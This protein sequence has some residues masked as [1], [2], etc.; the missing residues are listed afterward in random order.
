MF[1]IY[2]KQIFEIEASKAKFIN[3][4]QFCSNMAIVG[5]SFT[6]I[7]VERKDGP[8]GKMKV[9]NN[10][11]LKKLEKVPLALAGTENCL[12]LSFSFEALYEPK[13]GDIKLDGYI[14]YM[15]KEEKMEELLEI[16]KKDKK[17]PKEVMQGLMNNILSKCSVQAVILSRE[18]NLP[19]SIPVPRVT[20]K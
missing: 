11:A 14:L 8:L 17:L 12:R 2:I 7:L 20:V 1:L 18:I 6:K 13:V 4:P 5:F 16:W 10:V 19:P 3:G 15:E 9:S